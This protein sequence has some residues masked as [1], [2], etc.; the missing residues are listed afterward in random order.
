MV[1]APGKRI[2]CALLPDIFEGGR[3]KIPIVMLLPSFEFCMLSLMAEPVM[4]LLLSPGR[5][6]YICMDFFPK[7][8][9]QVQSVPRGPPHC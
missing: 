9:L 6:N 8:F 2:I 4:M 3:G 5:K 7:P 1:V